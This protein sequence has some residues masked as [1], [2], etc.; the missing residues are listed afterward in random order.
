MGCKHFLWQ[1]FPLVIAHGLQNPLEWTQIASKH[2]QIR[3]KTPP[4]RYLKTRAPFHLGA[5]GGPEPRAPL[6]WHAG[7]NQ[8]PSPAIPPRRLPEPP[9]L[10]T[11]PMW[12]HRRKPACVSCGARGRRWGRDVRS[13]LR[14]S[15]GPDPSWKHCDAELQ[16][17]PR[18]PR[19]PSSAPK[20]TVFGYVTCL[21]SPLRGGVQ[22]IR[23]RPQ[24]ADYHGEGPRRG[25]TAS[26]RS[27]TKLC[28]L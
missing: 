10:E 14:F 19:I 5:R 20:S 8:R 12:R 17:H 9:F 25:D 1:T 15:G 24:G 27:Q 16:L 28:P 2:A 13:A 6:P 3:L 11:R 26:G 7:V 23:K 22:L 18:C 4:A 21:L